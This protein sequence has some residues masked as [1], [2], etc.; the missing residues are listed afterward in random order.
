MA[1]FAWTGRPNKSLLHIS[2]DKMNESGRDGFDPQVILATAHARTG[3]A[4]QV[5]AGMHAETANAPQSAQTDQAAAPAGASLPQQ[6]G[7]KPL[8]ALLRFA[9]PL[10]QPVM[11]RLRA[12]FTDALRQDLLDSQNNVGREVLGLH[13]ML[14]LEM[15]ELHESSRQEAHRRYERLEQRIDS[16]SAAVIGTQMHMREEIRLIYTGLLDQM[17]STQLQLTEAVRLKEE[18]YAL[19]R[20]RFDDLDTGLNALHDA[21]STQNAQYRKDLQTLVDYLDTG[22]KALHEAQSTENAQSRQDLQTLVDL[23][24][25]L[26]AGVDTHVMHLRS[27]LDTQNAQYQQQQQALVSQLARAENYAYVGARRVA[28]PCGNGE[29][30][31]RTEA[32]YIMC[33]NTDIP[34][35]A[36]LIDTGDLE[37]GTRL[38]IQ[39]LLRPGDVFIDVGANIGMHT[40]A[41]GHAMAASGTIIANPPAACWRNP[42]GSTV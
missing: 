38:L 18:E 23:N 13:S 24:A 6:R 35:L 33:A 30:L 32:G 15:L 39:S 21:H 42:F 41:A 14:R 25:S 4:P 2:R 5:E 36:T 12:Y 28:V 22:L 10:L 31:V 11:S 27:L 40:L 7:A 19:L 26:R 1:R 34:L 17:H 16:A 8:R 29:M 3:T 37:R 9:K 20:A